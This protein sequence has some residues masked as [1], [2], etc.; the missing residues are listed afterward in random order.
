M[1][2]ESKSLGTAA[3][4]SQKKP[5]KILFMEFSGIFY[6][7]AP[8]SLQGD[9]GQVEKEEKLQKKNR[10]L[11]VSIP[12]I[13]GEAGT[14]QKEESGM[15]KMRKNREKPGKN[16][17]KKGMFSPGSEWEELPA[18]QESPESADSIP[19]E[20]IL[21]NFPPVSINSALSRGNLVPFPPFFGDLGGIWALFCK[22][23]GNFVPFFW[24]FGLQ[25]I[26]VFHSP[27]CFG[28]SGKK[29]KK[30]GIFSPL[31]T[32]FPL[33]TW[34]FHLL[35]G[36]FYSRVKFSVFCRFSALLSFRASKFFY[37]SHRFSI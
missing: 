7:G 6:Q 16:Q 20:E 37:F 5:K 19:S 25:P 2:G 10:F 11:G 3:I 33:T 32:N 30:I 13:P 1:L 34:K 14:F 17:G 31:A 28:N 29:K 15:R 24:H 21:R 12:E 36:N 26:Q 8:Y 4:P 22:S 23:Q 9:A 18:L 35:F 27:P